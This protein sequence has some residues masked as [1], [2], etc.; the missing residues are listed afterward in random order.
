MKNRCL[1]LDI[2]KLIMSIIM[3]LYHYN[4]ILLDWQ[5]AFLFP[6][7]YR[8][9]EVYFVIVGYILHCG[10]LAKKEKHESSFNWLKSRLI[11]LYPLYLLAFIVSIPLYLKLNIIES[12]KQILFLIKEAVLL[13]ESGII[14]YTS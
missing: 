3:V 9:C 13:Q 14:Y 10:V 2:L 5:N 8:L 11:N 1:D 6:C 7:G 12:W 4:R